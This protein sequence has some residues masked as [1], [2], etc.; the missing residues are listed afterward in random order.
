MYLLCHSSLIHSPPHSGKYFFNKNVGALTGKNSGTS[1][2]CPELPVNSRNRVALH[3]TVQCQTLMQITGHILRAGGNPRD[4]R[5]TYVHYSSYWWVTDDYAS[6]LTSK[7]KH[8]AFP[9]VLSISYYRGSD[10]SLAHP[11]SKCILF[12]GENTSFDASLVIY[13]YILLIFLQ[14][15]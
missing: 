15:W 4:C 8:A 3:L 11:T 7:E 5:G 14:L 9:C 10:K 13:I 2:L 12:D 1:I 6:M